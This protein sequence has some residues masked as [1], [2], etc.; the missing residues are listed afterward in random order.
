MT[1]H[2]LRLM[3]RIKRSSDYTDQK[4]IRKIRDDISVLNINDDN[5]RAIFKAASEKRII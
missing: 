5:N 2:Q 3:D 1:I 4:E